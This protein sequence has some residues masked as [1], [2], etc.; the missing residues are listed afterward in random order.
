MARKD[1]N[2]YVD[3]RCEK[4]VFSHYFY[5]GISGTGH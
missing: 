2:R 5:K 1:L 4:P 3:D